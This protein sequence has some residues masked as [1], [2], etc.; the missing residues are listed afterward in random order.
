MSM[1]GE[2]AYEQA[3]ERCCQKLA[4]KIKEYREHLEAIKALKE[5]GAEIVN[6]YANAPEI[7][8]LKQKPEWVVKYLKLFQ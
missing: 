4:N 1:G 6:E 5:L 3:I 8:S 2:Y 7:K